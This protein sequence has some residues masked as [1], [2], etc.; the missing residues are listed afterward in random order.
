MESIAGRGA[1]L[2]GGDAA[3]LSETAQSADE[4]RRHSEIIGSVSSR[5]KATPTRLLSSRTEN[6]D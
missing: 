6:S 3:F 1:P 5:R 4:L 2:P